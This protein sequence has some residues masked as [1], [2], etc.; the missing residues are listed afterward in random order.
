MEQPGLPTEETYEQSSSAFHRDQPR[1]P[2]RCVSPTRARRF[3]SNV[4]DRVCFPR[5][6]SPC[7]SAPEERAQSV[8]RSHTVGSAARFQTGIQDKPDRLG[9]S[10]SLDVCT[11]AF[12]C[13]AEVPVV[14]RPEDDC[15]IKSEQDPTNGGSRVGVESTG[16]RC[17]EPCHLTSLPDGVSLNVRPKTRTV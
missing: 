17:L 13:S 16:H 10:A 2:K 1:R 3:D 12:H 5:F 8:N 15:Q 11:N 6:R 4:I 7:F 9:E 14:P